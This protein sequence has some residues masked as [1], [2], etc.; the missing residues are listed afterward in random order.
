MPSAPSY[1]GREPLC[2]LVTCWCA[3]SEPAYL[4][5]RPPRRAGPGPRRPAGAPCPGLAV[6]PALPG[7]GQDLPGTAQRPRPD[8]RV[9]ARHRRRG[10]GAERPLP[11]W[12][13]PAGRPPPHSPR[14]A[15]EARPPAHL[16][17][18]DLR[19]T[20]PE[21]PPGLG[22]PGGP[23]GAEP[24]GGDRGHQPAHDHPLGSGPPVGGGRPPPGRS[25]VRGQPGPPGTPGLARPGPRHGLAATP[26]DGLRGRGRR[27]L[28]PGSLPPG[29]PGAAPAGPLLARRAGHRGRAPG[30]GP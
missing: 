29:R 23:P 4:R 27:H 8:R 13:G 28:P 30:P 15:A 1:G 9:P 22:R 20:R 18:P 21:R 12:P 6:P 19:G 26:H 10:P 7:A 25:R 14:P 24:P 16:P 11:G 5:P 17:G 2:H 3:S